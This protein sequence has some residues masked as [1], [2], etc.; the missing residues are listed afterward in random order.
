MG[1]GIPLPNVESAKE[2]NKRCERDN[3]P[4]YFTD[5]D[6]IVKLQDKYN[7]GITFNF[8]AVNDAF[9][10]LQDVEGMEINPTLLNTVL[11]INVKHFHEVIKK[12]MDTYKEKK[13]EEGGK[14]R[15]N[16]Q[17]QKQ[18]RKQTRRVRNQKKSLQNRL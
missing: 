14:R 4:Y 11:E 2:E 10:L 13:E 12:V 5:T 7:R 17:R 15:K 8:N 3:H 1:D 18:R 9:R 6:D 16:T